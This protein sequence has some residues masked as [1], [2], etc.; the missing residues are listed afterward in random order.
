[1]SWDNLLS[2]LVGAIVGAI[3]GF[4]GSVFLNWRNDKNNRRGAGRAVLAEIEMNKQ[5][6]RQAQTPRPLTEPPQFS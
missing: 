2:G 6:F 4:F 3:V 1:M 5:A